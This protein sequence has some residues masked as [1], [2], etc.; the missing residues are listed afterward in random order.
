MKWKR[1]AIAVLALGLAAVAL[2]ACS[3]GSSA[4]ADVAE[5]TDPD[6][7]SGPSSSEGGSNAV[8]DLDAT[9][10]DDARDAS[11]VGFG[12]QDATPRVFIQCADIPCEVDGDCPESCGGCKFSDQVCGK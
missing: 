7:A 6:A 4:E 1:L 10:A 9:V 2:A 3:D 5:A 8:D 12:E 11:W